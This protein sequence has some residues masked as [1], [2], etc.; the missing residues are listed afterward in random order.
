MA[1]V[2]GVTAQRAN[3]IEAASVTGA[4]I[5]GKNLILTTHGGTQINVGQVIPEMYTNY[6]VGSIYFTDRSANPATYMGG[7]T[8][9]RWGKGRVPVGVD[10]LDPDF[11]AADETGGA[12][13][14]TLTLA[15]IPNV[16]GQVV[17]H[18]SRSGWWDPSGVFSESN[19]VNGFSAPSDNGPQSS[20][21]TLEFN[22]GGGGQAHNNLQPYIVCYMWKRT[23]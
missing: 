2:T 4:Q 12:K 15:Q 7:G 22:L 9:V 6:A 19:S 18:S 14:H 16:I 13:T 17:A 23:A 20:L 11:D 10:E 3:E 21:S 1:T 5:Q 8:W